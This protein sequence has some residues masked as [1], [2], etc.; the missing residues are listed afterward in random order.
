MDTNQRNNWSFSE[1]LNIF[2][3][4]II[5]DKKKLRLKIEIRCL[6][7]WQDV[8]RGLL[9]F[10]L[11]LVL[12]HGFYSQQSIV[13]SILSF[14]S[15]F[16][17]FLYLW[18]ERWRRNREKDGIHL[19]SKTKRERKRIKNTWDSVPFSSYLIFRMEKLWFFG[20]I[21][22]I[23]LK[24]I[25]LSCFFIRKRRDRIYGEEWKKNYISVLY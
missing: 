11:F 24:Y 21:E 1:L 5:L 6:K 2:S 20:G 18:I 9:P 16:S 14:S 22:T 12:Q 15:S 13:H 7:F 3:I 4:N 17:L 23:F 8:S 25:Y 19:F 10:L